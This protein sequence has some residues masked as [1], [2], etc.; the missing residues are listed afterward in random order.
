MVDIALPS[1]ADA[2]IRIE[3][4]ILAPLQYRWLFPDLAALPDEDH[5]IRHHYRQ[6]GRGELA[7]DLRRAPPDRLLK[8]DLQQLSALPDAPPSDF[9]H[10]VPGTSATLNIICS[11]YAPPGHF[12]P[13][14]PQVNGDPQLYIKY[15]GHEFFQRGVPGLAPTIEDTAHWLEAVIARLRATRIRIIGFSG[16]AYGAILFGHLLSADAIHAVGPELMLGRPRYRSHQ[17]YTRREYHPLYRD[18][19]PFLPGLARRIALYYP[20]YDPMEFRSLQEARAAGITNIGMTADFHPGSH[21]PDRAALSGGP[22]LLVPVSQVNAHP[23]EQPFED[24]TVEHL[25][26]A[27]EAATDGDYDTSIALLRRIV[28]QHPRNHGFRCHLGIQM[29]LTG[30]VRGGVRAITAARAALAKEFPEY[31]ARLA[32]LAKPIV[33]GFYAPSPELT[34]RLEAIFDTD[35]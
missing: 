31:G 25:A 2:P 4:R 27:Y 3:G 21:A 24:D 16:A 14:L 32:R 8:L 29:A 30:N 34:R 22:E 28:A 17:W 7:A 18:L 5:V 12:A 26:T 1:D 33:R 20:A 15:D 10:Y 23:Y 19:R 9:F 35:P 6:N 13:V 11:H